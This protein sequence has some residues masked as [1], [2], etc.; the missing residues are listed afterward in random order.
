MPIQML[1]ITTDT[2]AHCGEVNQLIWCT[3]TPSS[4][5]LTTPDSL[6]SIHAQT[7]AETSSGSSHG[8]RNNARS[9]AASRKLRKKKTARANPI[10]NW[11]RIETPVNT[12]VLI[13]AGVNVEVW[14]T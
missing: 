5:A 3:P 10:E 1:A 7:D 8:T 12:P 4:T 14:M 11:K 9:V 6:F 13:R 2:S